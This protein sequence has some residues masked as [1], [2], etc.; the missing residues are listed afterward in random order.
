MDDLKLG[1]DDGEIGADLIGL[2]QGKAG[3]GVIG[4]PA[5]LAEYG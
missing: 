5:M 2:A 3:L 4:H 1:F